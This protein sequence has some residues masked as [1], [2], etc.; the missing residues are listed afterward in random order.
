MLL[1]DVSPR[2][3]GVVHSEYLPVGTH[4]IIHPADGVSKDLLYEIVHSRKVDNVYQSGCAFV[5][6]LS[7]KGE[8]EDGPQRTAEELRRS[9]L[10]S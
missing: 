10:S 1:R 7:G 9:I 2:G 8:H 3:M 5:C 4:F 6:V